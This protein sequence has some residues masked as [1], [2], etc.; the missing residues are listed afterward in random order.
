M[1]KNGVKCV[2]VIS[3]TIYHK[4][5]QSMKKIDNLQGRILVY[6]LNKLIDMK[7][8]MGK[9]K[10]AFFRLSYKCII[11]LRF[12]RK[13]KL[14]D[15]YRHIRRLRDLMRNHTCVDANLT[16]RLWNEGKE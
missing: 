3:E 4:V 5:N 9:V 10:F 15:G 16:F 11:Y 12:L 2:S 1:K 7:Y 8:S 13:G 14:S 6:D